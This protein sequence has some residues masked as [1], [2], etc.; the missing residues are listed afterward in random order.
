MLHGHGDD[1]HRY[2]RPLRADFSSNVR[3]DGPPAALRRHLAAE[4]GRIGRYPEPAA[5]SLAE[6]IAADLGLRPGEVLVTNGAAAAI[7]LVA[8][9][10][11]GA[12][13][14]VVEP[15]FSE[16]ADAA[17]IH[18]HELRRLRPADLDR[19]KIADLDL[20][21]LCTPNNPDGRVWPRAG[22]LGLAARH[23]R[24]LFVVDLAYS[25]FCD[26]LPPGPGDL[27]GH[28]NLILLHSLTKSFGIPGLRLGYV[29]AAP[30]HIARLAAGLA[31]WSV[32]ALALAA[33]HWCWPRRG[34]LAP[35][36]A[37]LLAESRR[38]QAALAALPG[39]R[40]EPSPTSFFL[41][42]LP[43]GTAAGLK[44]WLVG[45]HGL[46]IRDA[47]NFHGLGPRHFRVAA[48]APRHN[49]ALVEALR[50]WLAR[51]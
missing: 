14:G 38:L 25:D 1:R 22:L 10:W 23:P 21:W 46:L 24:T 32:N 27:R 19:E 2:D 7:H 26:A 41:V 35:P 36:R 44:R 50:T 3:P 5:E 51:G 9:A 48:Q 42:R 45:H 16:Y 20:V 49:R 47:A 8:Q 31:P 15:A 29:A 17:R 30:A 18:G 6:R 37:R 4:L 13:S 28:P 34:E 40:V 33:G 12:R 39:L 43:R 11:R